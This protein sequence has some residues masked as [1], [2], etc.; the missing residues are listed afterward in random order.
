MPEVVTGHCVTKG[1]DK[2]VMRLSRLLLWLDSPHPP[3]LRK[4]PGDGSSEIVEMA[5][6]CLWIVADVIGVGESQHQL[7]L[8]REVVDHLDEI[9]PA[10]LLEPTRLFL[11]AG[12][13]RSLL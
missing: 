9:V 10:P 8:D 1:A 12:L 3:T 2:M 6:P 7:W 5:L 4:L 13:R 11:S